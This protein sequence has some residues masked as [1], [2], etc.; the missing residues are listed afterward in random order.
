MAENITI[1]GQCFNLSHKKT[2]TKQKIEDYSSTFL[3]DLI[4]PDKKDL[5]KLSKINKN[6]NSATCKIEIYQQS[7]HPFSE[8]G[9]H[10]SAVLVCEFIDL[11]IRKIYEKK[12][13]LNLL[14]L[15]MVCKNPIRKKILKPAVSINSSSNHNYS[16]I[17]PEK[18][19]DDK[20]DISYDIENNSF[21]GNI[22][23]IRKKCDHFAK[24][25]FKTSS[26]LSKHNSF[27]ILDFFVNG[28]EANVK[29]I[30]SCETLSSNGFVLGPG[31]A[32]TIC[33]QLVIIHVYAISG[34][35]G[36]NKS[37]VV[38]NFKFICKKNI[39]S[40]N[41]INFRSKIKKISPSNKSKK[42][43]KIDVDCFFNDGDCKAELTYYF[44]SFS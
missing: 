19:G 12:L 9:F 17:K 38:S 24:N 20:I 41:T 3:A 6:D 26:D 2:L 5:F 40:P 10:L 29:I 14:Y 15:E 25:N 32:L 34:S 23:Y 42:H 27:N 7:I 36:K 44:E 18:Y 35:E 21:S 43:I 30:F 37:V 8:G 11:F 16:F 13:L 4:D 28:L 31:L 33:S 1:L 22:E 39:K